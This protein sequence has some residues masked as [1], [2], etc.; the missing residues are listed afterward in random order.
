MP[1]DDSDIDKNESLDDG[2]KA[3]MRKERAAR[4]EAARLARAAE[5]KAEE[6]AARLAELEKK[7]SERAE[8]ERKAAEKAQEESG[9][10]KEL[11]ET[12]ERERDEAKTALAAMTTERDA[13][14]TAANGLVK[15]EFDGLPD[16]IKALYTGDADD[17]VSM[18]AFIPKAKEAAAA[19]T[20][21][22][23]N[24]RDVDTNKP[25]PPANG[26]SKTK[27]QVQSEEEWRK[28]DAQ[29]YAQ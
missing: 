23:P 4:R 1:A 15:T 12:R 9:Q 27:A 28:A 22:E 16:T 2:A 26:D 24:T 3:V 29:R 8:T 6:T 18:L 14:R 17:P 10:Y 25:N 20:T 19:I 21:A 7:D 11:A 5:T 13:L